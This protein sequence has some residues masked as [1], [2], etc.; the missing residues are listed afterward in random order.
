MGTKMKLQESQIDFWTRNSYLIFRG[1]FANEISEIS[2]WTEEISLWPG[3]GNTK[4]LNFFEMHSP[5]KLSRVENFVPFHDGL[6]NIINGRKVIDIVSALMGEP[7]VLYKERIN[8]KPP[9]GGPHSA[10]QD[11]VAYES[12]HLKQFKL[13]TSYISMLL[14]IDPATV[15]NGC[16]QVAKNWQ[17][18]DLTIL[19]MENTDPDHLNFS[20]ISDEVEGNLEWESIETKPG[21]VI[22]FSE[23]LPHRSEPNRS[24][25]SRRILYGVFNPLSEG[26]KRIQYYEEKGKNINDPRY[27]VGNPHAQS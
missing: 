9:G 6:A 17:L 11:G 25:A 24:S 13:G 16:I 7:A 26:D 2:D 4:W 12:S 20:K 27:M 5:S 19:P 21:D 18:E 8:F 14:S 15:D 1:L 22:F 3:A 10:H 23:R